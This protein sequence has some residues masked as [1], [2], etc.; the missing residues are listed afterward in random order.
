[1]QEQTQQGAKKPRTTILDAIVQAVPRDG[2]PRS[3]KE[4]HQL[5]LAKSLFTFHAKDPVGIVR[6]AIRKH[7]AAHGGKDQPPAR[8]RQ[9]ERDRFVLA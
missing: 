2:V 7:L 8:I 3:S 6:S 5:I 4:I 1:M 9:V